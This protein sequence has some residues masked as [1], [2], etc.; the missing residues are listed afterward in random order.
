[1]KLTKE[2][3]EKIIAEELESYKADNTL[4]KEVQETENLSEEQLN[5]IAPALVALG[6][7]IGPQI[8]KLAAKHGPKIMKMLVDMAKTKGKEAVMAKIKELTS[9]QAEQPA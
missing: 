3:L 9:D 1:M 5:E 6:R 4:L 8:A 7:M 2:Y